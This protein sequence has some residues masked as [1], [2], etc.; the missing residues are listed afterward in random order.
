[1]KHI[2][3]TGNP[4]DPPLITHIGGYTV[5]DLWTAL[6]GLITIGHGNT[7]IARADIEAGPCFLKTLELHDTSAELERGETLSDRT[8]FLC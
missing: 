2:P 1:M 7:P 3:Q 5:Y 4:N 8:F 6:L